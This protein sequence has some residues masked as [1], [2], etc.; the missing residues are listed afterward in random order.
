MKAIIIPLSSSHKYCYIYL[1]PPV[2]TGLMPRGLVQPELAPWAPIS[3]SGNKLLDYVPC[4]RTLQICYHLYIAIWKF[5]G[6][7]YPRKG[8]LR[9]KSVTTTN[10]MYKDFILDA[11]KSHLKN[12][13]HNIDSLILAGIHNFKKIARCPQT[14]LLVIML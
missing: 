7:S 12:R 14:C 9:S 8:S 13:L 4:N 5:I 10:S 3:M 1:S 2:S 11:R 6:L